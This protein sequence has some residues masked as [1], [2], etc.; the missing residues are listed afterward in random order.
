MVV[1]NNNVTISQV[2]EAEPTMAGPEI[3]LGWSE[4]TC[5]SAAVVIVMDHPRPP[6]LNVHI[7]RLNT[8]HKLT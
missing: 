1:L 3:E 7:P 2:S 5:F 8:S 6:V 4:V